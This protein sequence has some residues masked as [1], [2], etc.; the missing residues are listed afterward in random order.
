MLFLPQLFKEM[1]FN[2]LKSQYITVTNTYAISEKTDNRLT[3]ISAYKCIFL[4]LI[5]GPPFYAGKR[6]SVDDITVHILYPS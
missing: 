6:K 2:K 4:L 5:S 1:R 3:N